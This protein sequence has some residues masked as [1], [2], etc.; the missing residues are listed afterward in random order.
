MQSCIAGTPPR[1]AASPVS[2]SNCS[3]QHV[4]LDTLLDEPAASVLELAQSLPDP[5]DQLG[6]ALIGGRSLT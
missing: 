6:A 5:P 3:G 4:E 2:A 1:K